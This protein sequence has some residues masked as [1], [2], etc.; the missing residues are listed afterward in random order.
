MGAKVG[1]SG[2]KG[3]KGRERQKEIA[4]FFASKI[5]FVPLL[6][7][8]LFLPKNVNRYLDY[9][10]D[11]LISV[12]ANLHDLHE[13]RGFADPEELDYLEGR[14]MSYQEVLGILKQSAREF[15]IPEAELGI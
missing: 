6:P 10:H 11:V 4:F 2:R 7:I 1:S 5:P 13:K 8:L 15:G 12:H 3:K 14:I 9:L